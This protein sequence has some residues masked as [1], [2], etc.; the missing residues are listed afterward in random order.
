MGTWLSSLGW[1]LGGALLFAIPLIGPILASLC[2]LRFVWLGFKAAWIA[3]AG[4]PDHI[5][6]GNCPYCEAEVLVLNEEGTTKSCPTCKHRLTLRNG[7]LV[8]VTG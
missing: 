2:L 7:N 3:V 6:Q 4:V 1:L 8:D 5:A